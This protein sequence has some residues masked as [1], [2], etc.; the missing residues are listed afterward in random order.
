MAQ[1]NDR[2]RRQRRTEFGLQVQYHFHTTLRKTACGG[3][4]LRPSRCQTAR[5]PFQFRPIISKEQAAGS[6][7]AESKAVPP[8]KSAFR[9]VE[10]HCRN[11]A[12]RKPGWTE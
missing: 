12:L 10:Y 8:Q 3:T 4:R 11:P 6:L 1:R 5:G 2:R 7:S 9:W